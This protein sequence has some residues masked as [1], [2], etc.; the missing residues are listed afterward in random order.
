MLAP[1]V[2]FDLDDRMRSKV[3]S[4]AICLQSVRNCYFTIQHLWHC[5][6]LLRKTTNKLD[7][8]F[9]TYRF[10]VKPTW[11]SKRI[12]ANEWGAIKRLINGKVCNMI[13]NLM[14][15]YNVKFNS[16]PVSAQPS[17]LRAWPFQERLASMCFIVDPYPNNSPSVTNHPDPMFLNLLLFVSQHIEGLSIFMPTPHPPTSFCS[18]LQFTSVHFTPVRIIHFTSVHTTSAHFVSIHFSSPHFSSR[19]LSSLHFFSLQFAS[20]QFTSFQLD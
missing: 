6:L 5:S 15:A 14:R 16:V 20:R 9:K 19:H 18:F 3:K 1:R 2:R 8:E 10:V 17:T 12:C 11:L 7:N 4:G 13:H